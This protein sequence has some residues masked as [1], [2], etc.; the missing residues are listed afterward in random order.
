MWALADENTKQVIYDCHLRA[1]DRVV[2][3][4]E[5]C[6]FQLPVGD[7]GVVEEDINGVIAAAFTHFDSRAGDP[8]LHDHVV[9]W[10]RARSVS[11]GQWRTLDS[12][13]LF[14]AVV[15]LS[16]LHHGVLSDYLTERSGSAGMPGRGSTRSVP[17]GRSAVSPRPS[18]RSS[19]PVPPR[20]RSA[21][22]S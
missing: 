15:A 11:D 16:E 14:K 6:V 1:I 13:G 18:W 20:S 19:R 2:E 7:N 3:Y 4:A 9:V 5:G 12:R 8:Q 10:N 22:T 17:G 21:P